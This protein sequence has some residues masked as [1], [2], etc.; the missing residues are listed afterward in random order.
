MLLLQNVI[1]QDF[2]LQIF[3]NEFSLRQFLVFKVLLLELLLLLLLFEPRLRFVPTFLDR[4][5]D[6]GSLHRLGDHL[7]VLLHE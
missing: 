4:V 2:L 1:H 5:R 3:L 6:N 7:D